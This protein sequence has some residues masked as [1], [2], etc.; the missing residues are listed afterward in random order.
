MKSK[1]SNI[2]AGNVSRYLLGL[3]LSITAFCGICGLGAHFNQI[4]WLWLATG[5]LAFTLFSFLVWWLGH[6]S[7]TKREM[8]NARN[9]KGDNQADTINDGK[10]NSAPRTDFEFPEVP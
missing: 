4:P 3:L 8:K 5:C 9:Q 1:F 7:T 2:L 6:L 10:S